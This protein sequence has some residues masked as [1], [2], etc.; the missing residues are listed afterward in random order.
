[1][2]NSGK[3]FVEKAEKKFVN[4]KKTQTYEDYGDVGENVKFLKKKK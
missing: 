2:N 3:K 1:M 4:G